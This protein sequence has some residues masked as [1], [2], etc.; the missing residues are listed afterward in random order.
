[1]SVLPLNLDVPLASFTF[2]LPIRVTEV[3]GINDNGRWKSTVLPE[4]TIRAVVLVL[5]VEALEF[6][7]GGD[8]SASGINLMTK[9]EL[10][11]TDIRNDGD[12]EYMDGRQSFIHYQG[13]KFRV[14]GDGFTMGNAGYRSYNCLR[15]LEQEQ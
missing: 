10:Y 5:D 11:F 4:R 12:G 14:I 6:L 8:A 15:Y 13:Y 7:S 3:E 1:M 2:P 9:S